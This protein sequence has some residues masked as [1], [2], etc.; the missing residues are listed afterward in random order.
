MM[1]SLSLSPFTVHPPSYLQSKSLS[2]G[3][4]FLL[5]CDHHMLAY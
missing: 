5:L 1:V 3:I 4:K 2:L